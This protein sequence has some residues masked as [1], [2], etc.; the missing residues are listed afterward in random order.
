MGFLGK[1]KRGSTQELSKIFRAPI[2]RAHRAV[3]FAIAE[4]SFIVFLVR[5]DS[6]VRYRP[7]NKENL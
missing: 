7:T 5:N 1:I 2:Y 6:A 3:I 4:L